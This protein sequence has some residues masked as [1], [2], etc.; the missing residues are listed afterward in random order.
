M[1]MHSRPIPQ[2]GLNFEYVMWLFTR[3][4]GLALYLLAITGI[5]A[6]FIL[7]AR[8]QVD[9]GALAR[10]TFF[11]NPNHVV[12]TNIPD[13]T[14]GWA[15]AWWQIMQMLLLSFGVTHGMNGIR[16]VIEDYLGSSWSKVLLRGA[17]FLFWLFMLIIGIYVILAS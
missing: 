8:T 14:L 4:S 9:I 11:P 7:G 13:V 15:N 10:W 16:V 1:E 6:A 12:N 17:V 2:I 3:I 5:T